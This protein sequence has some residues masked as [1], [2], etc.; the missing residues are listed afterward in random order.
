MSRPA[1]GYARFPVFR[2][3]ALDAAALMVWA[4]VYSTFGWLFS[5]RVEA[6]IGTVVA[7]SR[8]TLLAALALVVAAGAW[9]LVKM[10]AHHAHHPVIEAA[11]GSG[12]APDPALVSTSPS[13][14]N[15]RVTGQGSGGS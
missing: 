13:G 15:R 5:G 2:F 1:A 11:G 3:L 14:P 9:R 6:V 8:W 12:S 4:T 10:R 7:Y